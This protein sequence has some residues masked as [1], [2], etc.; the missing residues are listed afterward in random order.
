MT[1]HEAE[2]LGNSNEETNKR[3]VVH[4]SRSISLNSDAR[5]L[6]SGESNSFKSG[7]R[8]ACLSASP[9]K[10]ALV[11]SAGEPRT[12]CHRAGQSLV[13]IPVDESLP[14]VQKISTKS[15]QQNANPNVYKQFRASATDDHRASKKSSPGHGW[16][17]ILVGEGAAG[18]CW[19]GRCI[20]TSLR[21][22]FPGACI[23]WLPR[24]S[25]L[26]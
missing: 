4:N 11:S 7:E 5:K 6:R 1:C 14:F 25:N 9:E 12:L 24:N 10:P 3:K 2:Q 21:C 13:F 17:L 19:F 18:R 8:P 16:D 26:D 23:R 22:G 15:I 20:P